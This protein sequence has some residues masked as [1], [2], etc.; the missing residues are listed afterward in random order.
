MGLDGKPLKEC[1]ML[2]FLS[3]PF[4]GLC[5]SCYTLMNYLIIIGL[6]IFGSSSSGLLTCETLWTGLSNNSGASDVRI[7][8][9]VLDEKSSSAV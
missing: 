8:K 1:L 6:L 2:L 3:A 4:W 7:D 9:S 5:I